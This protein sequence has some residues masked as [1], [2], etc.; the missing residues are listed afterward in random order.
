MSSLTTTIRTTAAK[1]TTIKVKQMRPVVDLFCG[2]GGFSTGAALAGS[3]IIL[4]IDN[5]K[6]ALDVHEQNHPSCEHLLY[7]LGGDLEKTAQL[8]RSYL[9]GISEWHL[10]GSPPCQKLSI[11]NR[12]NNDPDEGM[13][14]VKWYY[15]LVK[16]LQPTSWCMEEVSCPTLIKY[17]EEEE[18]GLLVQK[19]NAQDYGLPQTRR[20]LF[21]GQG[22]SLTPTVSKSKYKTVLDVLPELGLEGNAIRGY[23]TSRPIVKKGQYIGPRKVTGIDGSKLLTSPKPYT[24]C[25][26]KPLGLV[27][28]VNEDTLKNVRSLTPPE[29]AILMGFPP[30]YKFENLTLEDHYTMIGN[31]VCPPIAT[32]LMRGIFQRSNEEEGMDNNNNNNNN[33][34]NF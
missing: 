17:L 32:A 25:A 15:D 8:I 10:H 21:I 33:N 18:E 13:R 34:N 1:A 26:S 31:S 23:S 22:W 3:K 20:R 28:I 12:Q 19:V 6:E 4:A 2:C 11:A 14:L 9:K 27:N 16:I 30:Q 5:W 7:E 24:L 29:C